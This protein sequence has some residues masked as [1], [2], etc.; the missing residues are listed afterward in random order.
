MAFVH[1]PLQH[2][3][4]LLAFSTCCLSSSIINN[5]TYKT[6]TPQA[7]STA[8]SQRLVSKLIHHNSIHHPNYNPNETP[9]DQMKLD[10]QHSLARLAYLQAR[11]IKGSLVSDNDYRVSLSPSLQSRT[12]LANLSIGQPPIPQLVIMD[13]GSDIF[14]VM[15]TPCPTCVHHQVPLFDP[16]KSSTYS[17]S[18]RTVTP[19]CGGS[20]TTGCECDLVDRFL[21][22]I[23]YADYSSSSGTLGHDVL[24]FETADEGITRVN[25]IEFGCGHNIVYNADPGYSGILGLALS[26]HGG[27]SF[28]SQIG[29]K[30]SYCIGS[31]TDKYYSY[32][33]LVLGEGADFEGYS[34]NLQVHHGFYYVTMECISIGEKRLD[35]AQGAFE[36]KRDGTGGVIIDSGSTITYLV[37]EVYELLHKEVS[38]LLH[39]SFKESVSG[40]VPWQLCYFGNVGRDLDGFP[41]VTFHFAGGADLVLDTGSLFIQVRDSVFCMTVGPTSVTGIEID[42]SVI[43]VLAQQSYNVGYDIVNGFIYF[44]RIECQL[45]SG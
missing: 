33:Q 17:P 36:M 2:L 4:L 12:I 44:Q 31:L 42:L 35:I 18:C 16:S 8:K 40:N 3:L 39:G 14:W 9:E 37:D 13:T 10:T 20:N 22:N 34:T 30:F 19:P 24:V 29:Q 41:V 23:T 43:G 21:Y 7:A 27:L 25:N 5:T 28:A 1:E 38:N 11:I 26:S 32:N 45:L 15:C 6:T